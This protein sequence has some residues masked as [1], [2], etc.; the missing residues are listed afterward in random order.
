MANGLLNKCNQ[1]ALKNWVSFY[2]K[3]FDIKYLR[4]SCI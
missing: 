1:F 2:F 3:Y 4:N